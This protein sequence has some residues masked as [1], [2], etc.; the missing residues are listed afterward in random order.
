M[1]V[2]LF[3]PGAS[4]VAVGN[5]RAQVNLQTDNAGYWRVPTYLGRRSGLTIFVNDKPAFRLEQQWWTATGPPVTCI[6]A[7]LCREVVNQRPL[8]A[9]CTF[10][11]ADQQVA[12]V[13]QFTQVSM[14]IPIFGVWSAS[15]STYDIS[16]AV[17]RPRLP[18]DGVST[19]ADGLFLTS[20]SPLGLW[21]YELVTVYGQVLVRLEFSL[22]QHPRV[23]YRTR[24]NC[25]LRR[26]LDVVM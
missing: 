9:S 7:T 25:G 10:S 17:L 19:Y 11:L 6:G 22:T 14:S 1:K 4:K 5:G 24:P 16:S 2:I 26:L 3:I 8:D 21:K 18:A 15:G 13:G 20:D 23:S 12:F